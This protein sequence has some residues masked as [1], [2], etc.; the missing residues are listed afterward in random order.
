MKTLPSKHIRG[1]RVNEQP[2]DILISFGSN[3]PEFPDGCCGLK[4]CFANQNRLIRNSA[5]PGG[6]DD[7]AVT[8]GKCP[9]GNIAK[10]RDGW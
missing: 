10:G 8:G 9:S 2:T 6:T 1:Q 7:T 4:S 3:H 5:R